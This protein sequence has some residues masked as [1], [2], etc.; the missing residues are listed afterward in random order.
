MTAGAGGTQYNVLTSIDQ[1]GGNKKQGLVSTTNTPV[2]LDSHIRVRGGGHNRNWV[3]CMN[4]LG[5]VGRR[6]GQSSGPGNRAGVSAVCHQIA[7]KRKQDYPAK[8]P[9]ANVRGWGA[10]Y[11]WS[12]WRTG[13]NIT[14]AG[15]LL[16]PSTVPDTNNTVLDKLNDTLGSATLDPAKYIGVFNNCNYQLPCKSGDNPCSNTSD[17][18]GYAPNSWCYN[19]YDNSIG[20]YKWFNTVAT[21]A[22]NK[23]GESGEKLFASPYNYVI[24]YSNQIYMFG[25]QWV[26]TPH[27]P[28]PFNSLTEF[29]SW[30]TNVTDNS[31]ANNVIKDSLEKTWG[32][33][34]IWDLVPPVFAFD[35]E[36]FLDPLQSNRPKLPNG[37]PDK[38]SGID[39]VNNFINYSRLTFTNPIFILVPLGK[40]YNNPDYTTNSGATPGS[41]FLSNFTY[42]APMVYTGAQSYV[43]GGGW[44]QGTI[45]PDL[46]G[47]NKA[48][49]ATSQYPKVILTMQ[50][51]GAANNI[52]PSAGVTPY[53]YN[54]TDVAT[55]FANLLINGLSP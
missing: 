28:N 45:E 33:K 15:L 13:D 50:T 32:W 42:V 39:K 19:N 38:V 40:D 27:S 46:K 49:G 23:A 54:N 51:D 14:F 31:N 7:R 43:T 12:D 29:N 30:Y 5:G 37:S 24:P 2:A 52:K 35:M 41:T 4:Q 25:G 20:Q 36:G 9:G 6:W 26:V 16:W 55:Y 44:P 34:N 22:F 21:G 10:A 18:G 47:W 11:K 53:T 17:G 1:G 3:F 48:I 8:P